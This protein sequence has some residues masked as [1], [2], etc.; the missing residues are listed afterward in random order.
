[1]RIKTLVCASF[2]LCLALLPLCNAKQAFPPDGWQGAVL[3]KSDNGNGAVVF[4]PGRTEA[5]FSVYADNAQAGRLLQV[6]LEEDHLLIDTRAAY[7]QGSGKVHIMTFGLDISAA[8]GK[9]YSLSMDINGT[10]GS[11]M[12]IYFEGRAVSRNHYYSHKN[13]TLLGQRR[14]YQYARELPSDLLNLH[15]RYDFLTPG[16][17]KFY[18]SAFYPTPP[19]P[20]MVYPEP[21]LL[22]HADFDDTTEATFA[23]GQAQALR[24]DNVSFADGIKGRAIKMSYADKSSLEYSLPGNVDPIRGTISLWY[25]PL[26]NEGER[27]SKGDADWRN[28]FG[29]ARPENRVGSG[30]IWL[31]YWN[32]RL[33]GDLADDFDGYLTINPPL[34]SGTW[35]HIA[36]TWNEEGSLLYYNGRPTGASLSDSYSPIKQA[37]QGTRKEYTR[38]EPFQSFF[39][40]SMYNRE[41]ADGL[42]DDLK[43]YSAPL[44]A[45]AIK[46]LSQEM[47]K[48]SAVLDTLY[49]MAGQ[50]AS[51]SCMVNNLLAEPQSF[52]WVLQDSTGKALVKGQLSDVP[53]KG[54]ATIALELPAG[55]QPGKHQLLISSVKLAEPISQD[56]WVLSGDNPEIAADDK[57]QM[58]LVDSLMLD[59]APDAERFVSV[60]QC[61][62]GELNGVKYLEAAPAKGSRFAIRFQLPD[63]HHLYCFEL[64]YPDD[65]VRTADILVQTSAHRGG[66]YELQTGYAAGDEYPNQHK[67]VTSRCLYWANARD[68]SVIFMTARE[69]APAAVAAIRVYKVGSGLPAAPVIKPPT[70]EGWERVVAL[71]YE[72]PAINYDFAASGG[73][74]PGLEAMINRTAAYMK[75][76][77]QNLLAY[78]GSWYQGPIGERYNPR[79]HAQQFLKAFYSKFDAE[80]LYF[81]PTINQN[82]I[83][84]PIGYV[85]RAS[86]ADGSL[87]PKAISIWD[88]GKPNPGGWHNT[89]PNF[90]IMHPEVM[91]QITADIDAMIADGKDHPSFKGVVFHLT[92]HCLLWFG[93]IQAGYNDYVIDAF[94][95]ETGIAVPAD[96]QNPLRGKEYAAWLNANA[97]DEWIAWRCRTLARWYKDIAARLAAARPD[98][99][100]VINSFMPADIR[101]P[102]FTQEDFLDT[103]NREAGLDARLFA[104]TANV[105]ICQALVPA[106]YRWREAHAYG[107]PEAQAHQ[108]ILDTLPGFYNALN[109]ARWPWIHMHDRYWESAIGNVNK[110]DKANS[111][112]V[113]WLNEH[114]WRVSTINP[115]SYHAMRHYVLP[116][117]YHDLVGVSKG[118]FLVGTYGMEEYLVPFAR[119][120]RALP[121][122]VFDDIESG[123]EVVKVR[124]CNFAGKTWFYVVNTD[125]KPATITLNVSASAITDLLTNAPAREHAAGKTAL[126]LAPYQLR[127]FSAPAGTSISVV[128]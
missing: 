5:T 101:H 125:H 97:R 56:L 58:D 113:P 109:T 37:L 34:L 63:D 83:P 118:G 88:T 119:A 75:Y 67:I 99:R 79:G 22:F 121:A 68:V 82:N 95:R 65:K 59:S 110:N 124:Q 127:S 12:H 106:D 60:G 77:G 27:I 89:P 49:V 64:D 108:R 11:K 73:S 8:I 123:S 7:E 17:Y 10:P 128:R 114:R 44:D 76:S 90:N 29:F 126:S 36:F 21:E 2:A 78:P 87:H 120:F 42:I 15:L 96:R 50:T 92:R 35:R 31:W 71:Y 62:I 16:V 52:S 23:K 66:E 81:M 84:V 41:Q 45:A 26:W 112:S 3:K 28:L 54:S 94:T 24:A 47:V 9:D 13:I 93:D 85:S 72:D 80:G 91:G 115:A 86:L 33:R 61:V 6:S 117:R 32:T 104:D 43:I 102:N 122:K 111:L 107:S 74:M 46:K 55:S 14:V 20:P 48:A 51:M 70:V 38:G 30:D 105:V 39:V 69:N 53:A 98:L 25:K 18:A 4:L 103:M 1:M 19:E 40:G 100:L 116:L 57:L